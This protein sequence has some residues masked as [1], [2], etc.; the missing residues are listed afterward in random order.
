L[1]PVVLE[2]VTSRLVTTA[3]QEIGLGR[4]LRLRE[5]GLSQAGAKD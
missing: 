4:L 2:Y 3:S 1:H 5:H